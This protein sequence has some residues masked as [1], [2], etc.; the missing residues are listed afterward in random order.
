MM[1]QTRGRSIDLPLVIFI[2]LIIKLN[3]IQIY[4]SSCSSFSSLIASSTA[5]SAS[6]VSAV[7]STAFSTASSASSHASKASDVSF[8]SFQTLMFL[9]R[10]H[11]RNLHPNPRNHPVER[12]FAECKCRDCSC[13]CGSNCS[14]CYKS[15]IFINLCHNFVS[16]FIYRNHLSDTLNNVSVILLLLY[17][18]RKRKIANLTSDTLQ[19]IVDGFR[20]FAHDL[21]NLYVAVSFHII[22]QHFI[23]HRT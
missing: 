6:A 2:V 8:F 10:S 18:K 1:Q 7:S 14:D 13:C 11:P 20:C 19:R 21:R 16:P 22:I 5:C 23:F 3:R 12:V 15:P 17:Q 9:L 4:S